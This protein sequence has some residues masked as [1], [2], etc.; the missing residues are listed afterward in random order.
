MSNVIW[1]KKVAIFWS[2][3]MS[4]IKENLKQR[5]ISDMTIST[6]SGCNN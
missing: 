5:G 2:E 1:M 4:V 6:V 3:R